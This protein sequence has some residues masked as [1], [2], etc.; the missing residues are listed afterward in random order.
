MPKGALTVAEKLAIDHMYNNY[1]I[2][3]I[4]EKLERPPNSSIIERYVELKGLK[5]DNVSLEQFADV[6]K[7]SVGEAI[8]DLM[9]KGFTQ[10]LATK[11]V[12][13]AL[14][15]IDLTSEP[16]KDA[17]VSFALHN[18]GI[19]IIKTKS[20]KGDTVISM[21]LGGSLIGD[22]ERPVGNQMSDYVFKPRG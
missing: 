21:N 12:T 2:K 1:T 11:H 18:P 8:K 22:N 19:D 17:L 15:K 4:K 3:E 7:E 10:D 14:S 13:D 6:W 9:S 16:D 20:K 5:K